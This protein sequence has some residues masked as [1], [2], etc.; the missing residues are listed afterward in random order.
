[1]TA[2]DTDRAAVDAQRPRFR[3]SARTIFFAIVLVV[4][5]VYLQQA[6]G[7]EWRTAAG[8]IGPG[9]FP[10]VIGVLGVALTVVALARSVWSDRAGT[11]TDEPAAGEEEEGEADLGRHP[12]ITALVVAACAGLVATYVALGAVVA[13]ALFLF[14]CLWLLNRSRPALNAAISVGLAVGLYLLFETLLGAGLPEGV[15]P[16]LG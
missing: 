1:V 16:R 10:R 12:G 14:G 7:M 9:F 8:R 11:S 2:V 4:L 6:M 5:G 15:L 3:V 13:S